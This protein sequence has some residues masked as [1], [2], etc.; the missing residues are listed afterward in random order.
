M[1]KGKEKGSPAAD[2]KAQLLVDIK[3]VPVQD[4]KIVNGSTIDMVRLDDVVKVVE[5]SSL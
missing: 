1:A 2:K 5:N 3:A 4:R